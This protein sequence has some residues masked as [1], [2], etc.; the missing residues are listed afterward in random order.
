MLGDAAETIARSADPL[1][2]Q[3]YF[4]LAVK[5]WAMVMRPAP[6]AE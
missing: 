4:D 3:A 2:A 1:T 6:V 5:C